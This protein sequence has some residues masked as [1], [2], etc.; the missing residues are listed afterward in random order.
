LFSL[1]SDDGY[2]QERKAKLIDLS[3]PDCY[4]W[5]ELIEGLTKF[6]KDESFIAPFYDYEN[7]I[8]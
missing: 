8:M 4:N 2:S 3:N 1:T 7:D 6:K 5:N